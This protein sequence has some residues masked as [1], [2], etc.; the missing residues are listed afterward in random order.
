MENVMQND[1]FTGDN[2]TF[3]LSQI[4]QNTNNAKHSLVRTAG[5]FVTINGSKIADPVLTEVLLSQLV[6]VERTQEVIDM[7]A[8]YGT[9]RYFSAAVPNEMEAFQGAV[10]LDE[11]VQICHGNDFCMNLRINPTKKFG[12]TASHQNEIVSSHVPIQKVHEI[13][14]IVGNPNGPHEGWDWNEGM[15]YTWHPGRVYAR[16]ETVVKLLE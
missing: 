5:S 11:F 13:W 7:G 9:C 15:V 4:I 2:P 16:S 12:G 8:A 6:L 14:V 10:S 3:G 1:V